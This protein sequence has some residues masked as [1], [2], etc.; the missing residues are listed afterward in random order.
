M[1]LVEKRA[2][3]EVRNASGATP[4]ITACAVGFSSVVKV[5]LDAGANPFAIN[6]RGKN[7]LDSNLAVAAERLVF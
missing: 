6:N 7:A 5:L 3:L 1:L 2:N 4:L